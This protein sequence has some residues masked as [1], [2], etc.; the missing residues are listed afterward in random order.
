MMQVVVEANAWEGGGEVLSL[1]GEKPAGGGGGG[2]EGGSPSTWLNERVRWKVEQGRI[3]GGEPLMPE[4]EG[5]VFLPGGCWVRLSHREEGGG[6]RGA[7]GGAIRLEAGSISIEAAE[8][9]M[10]V[11]EYER[12]EGNASGAL[13][14][15]RVQYSTVL[16]E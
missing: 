11:H 1:C 10:L 5:T 9:K 12:E 6:E 2:R 14:L 4:R 7:G 15:A 3:A 16:T 8:T 13:H